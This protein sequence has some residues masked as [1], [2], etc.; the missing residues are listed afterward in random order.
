[1]KLVK[2]FLRWLGFLVFLIAF[3]VLTLEVILWLTLF[4]LTRPLGEIWFSVS[5][6]GINEAQALIQRYISPLLWEKIIAP[7]L[8]KP[9]W[10]SLSGVAFGGFA[11]GFFLRQ[12]GLPR[13]R[14]FY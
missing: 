9:A 11:F 7:L 13:R 14:Y 5:P 12:M 2:F 6:A 8:I 1:M 3:V 4:D 10:Q